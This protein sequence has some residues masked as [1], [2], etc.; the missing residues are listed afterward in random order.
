MALPNLPVALP[1]PPVALPPPIENRRALDEAY[2]DL[3]NTEEGRLKTL[4]GGAIILEKK[5]EA[6]LRKKRLPLPIE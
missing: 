6:S 5:S 2:S 1:F 4:D 3:H